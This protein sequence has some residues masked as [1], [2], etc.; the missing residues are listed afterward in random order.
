MELNNFPA[1]KFLHVV[2]NTRIYKEYLTKTV[3][4]L[5]ALLE[6]AR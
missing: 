1:E 3:G 2:K 4:E 5:L 6:L